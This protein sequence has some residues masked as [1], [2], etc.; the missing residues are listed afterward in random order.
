MDVLS[1]EKNDQIEIELGSVE[2][3]SLIAKLEDIRNKRI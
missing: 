2:T 3:I 1:K